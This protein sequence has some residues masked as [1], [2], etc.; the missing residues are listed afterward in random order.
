MPKIGIPRAL[1]YHDFFPGWEEYLEKMGWEIVVSPPSTQTIKAMGLR[2]AA[3]ELC[4]PVKIFF[5]HATYLKD[6]S[7]FLFVPR[8]ISIAENEYS[9]PKIIGLRDLVK[10]FS[11]KLP[12]LLS[13]RI[14]LHRPNNTFIKLTY[15][16]SV[17]TRSNPLRV[18][19]ALKKAWQK[20]NIFK[21][22]IIDNNPLFVNGY[23]KP[24]YLRKIIGVFG[25]SYILN[26]C[27]L[28]R[29]ILEFLKKENVQVLTTNMLAGKFIN[30]GLS[31]CIK[32]PFWTSNADSLG[33]AIYL[34]R[35]KLVQGLILLSSF[36]CGPDSLVNVL[37]KKHVNLPVL[38]LTLDEHDSD[39]G[40]ITRLEAFLDLLEGRKSC[41]D[42][43]Y[44]SPPGKSGNGPGNSI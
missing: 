2:Y 14:D 32:K 6:K 39:S 18:H 41:Q 5:G 34:A 23:S 1:H 4:F 11:P 29:G 43:N 37:I 35:N 44:F 9:C 42:E 12:P 20:Q 31:V 16:V 26:D 24:A 13:P 33:A 27:L 21:N 28:G 3:D 8:I 40:L 7:D 15:Q 17:S 38:I 25:H 19:Y 10:G 22:K 36:G 30:E